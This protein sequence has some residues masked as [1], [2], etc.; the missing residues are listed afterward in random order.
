MIHEAKKTQLPHTAMIVL[1]CEAPRTADTTLVQAKV[2]A[3]C[4]TILAIP[5]IPAPVAPS[6]GL[7]RVN[8]R[9]KLD[10]Q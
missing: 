8:Y 10:D 1:V 4:K 7:T 3:T 5:P 2:E 9:S 6:I